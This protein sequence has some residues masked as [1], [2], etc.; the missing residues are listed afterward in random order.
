MNTRKKKCA[1]PI[2]EMLGLGH[3]YHGKKP[4]VWIPD[5]YPQKESAEKIKPDSS[6]LHDKSVPYA[7]GEFNLS[8]YFIEDGELGPYAS[9]L[10]DKTFKKTFSPDT[11]HGKRNLLNLLNDLLKG[12]IP[13]KIKDIV[14]QQPE[15]NDSGSNES[16]S[17]ILDLHCRDEK[18]NFIEI[19]VQVRQKRNFTKRL[20]FY[21]CQMVVQQGEP[22]SDWEYDVK[23]VYVVS[24]TKF[25]VFGDERAVHRAGILDL[26]TGERLIDSV[27][28]TIVELSK[29]G[30]IIRKSDPEAAKWMFI[31]RYLDR[32]KA[33]PPALNDEKFKSLLEFARLSRFSK[34][35]LKRYRYVM[36]LKWDRYAEFMAFADDNPDL[37][38]KIKDESVAKALDTVEKMLNNAHLMSKIRARLKVLK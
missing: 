36:H 17:S 32:L 27:N 15:L 34:E 28:Y 23:P 30:K 35:E 5:L 4:L 24:F 31:F 3:L 33:L 37:I 11:G 21:S 12:Q 38:Q 2:I 29:V 19:E 13:Q 9:L 1:D 18:G 7:A 25:R 20:T 16:K 8:E 6:E 26:D 22:G 10:Y 14:S